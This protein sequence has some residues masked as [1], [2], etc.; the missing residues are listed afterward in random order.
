MEDMGEQVEAIFM[1][2]SFQDLT[3]QRIRK[4]LDNIRLIEDRLGNALQKLGITVEIA[5]SA[6]ILP[7]AASQDEIDEMFG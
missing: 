6:E 7:Q 5:D 3:S 4:T 2:C 1:A